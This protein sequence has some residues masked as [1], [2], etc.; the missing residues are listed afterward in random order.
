LEEWRYLLT[1]PQGEIEVQKNPTTWVADNSWP[2]L[3]RNIHAVSLLPAFDG[4]EAFFFE[5]PDAF[6]KYYDDPNPHK[7]ELPGI[8]NTKL[9]SLEKM[10]LV[11]TIRPDK[12]IPAVQD[13]V[14]EKLGKEF[15]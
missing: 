9:D 15:I 2:D 3:F 10:I 11:K 6:F 13:W 14:S 4:F 12:V 7:L 5:N 1:G 8:W